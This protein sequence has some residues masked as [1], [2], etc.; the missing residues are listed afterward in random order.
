MPR[1]EC[2][3]V[4]ELTPLI[5]YHREMTDLLEDEDLRRNEQTIHAL[6]W[7]KTFLLNR[8]NYQRKQQVKRKVMMRLITEHDLNVDLDDNIKAEYGEHLENFDDN[9][10]EEAGDD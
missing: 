2:P 8:R 4:E 6:D 3:A 10:E 5:S 7:L 1:Q 9:N